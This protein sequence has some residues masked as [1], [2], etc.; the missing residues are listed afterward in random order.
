[1]T[2]K[3]TISSG[4]DTIKLGV[5]IPHTLG[6]SNQSG[7]FSGAYYSSA[8]FIAKGDINQNKF[9]LKSKTVDLVWGSTDCNKTKTVKLAMKVIEE[10]HVDA[11]VGVGCEGC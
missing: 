10:H 1:M 11:I 7:Y 2:V 5:L 6:S 4:K 3:C 9:L 8:V